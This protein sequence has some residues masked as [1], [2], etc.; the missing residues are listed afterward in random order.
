MIKP[1]YVLGLV[2]ANLI[3][4]AQTNPQVTANLVPVQTIL[5]VEARHDHDKDIPSLE[6]GDVMAYERSDR[7]Q[8]T[9]LHS[10]H[11]R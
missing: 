8:V 10:C 2:V 7:L 11:P 3:V 5:T 1:Y 4:L 9:D 6:S